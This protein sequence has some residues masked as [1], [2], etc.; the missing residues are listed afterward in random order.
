MRHSISR[1]TVLS[2]AAALALSSVS[3]FASAAPKQKIAV[4]CYSRS[5]NT[6][7]LAEMIAAKTGAKLFRIDVKVPY[8]PSYSDM[9][10]GARA[11]V[12]SKA[13]KELKEYPDLSGFDTVFVG[14]PYWWGGLST[15]MRSYLTK[16]SLAGKKVYPFIT[17]GSSSPEG[18]LSAMRELL[19]G[20][21]VGP[22]F[23]TPGGQA[24]S[25]SADITEWLKK[26][27]F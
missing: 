22:F 5:G 21:D 17:S 27:G 13:T 6:W 14:S 3:V 24:S 7:Q 16:V 20:A 23:Y 2:G 8:A 9:T 11:E 18:A 15:P 25:A 26:I 10:G 4:V 19:K 1:R 12:Q